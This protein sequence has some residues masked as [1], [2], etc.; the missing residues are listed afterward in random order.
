MC[1]QSEEKTPKRPGRPAGSR[2]RQ[3]DIVELI[4]TKCRCGSINRTPYGP[5]PE[6]H[7]QPFSDCVIVTTWQK[8]QCTDC[9]QWRKDKSQHREPN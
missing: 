7:R 8:T 9:G 4:P 3:Y 5:N 2:N 1:K 6:T